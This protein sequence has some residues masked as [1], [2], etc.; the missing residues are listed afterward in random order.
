VPKYVASR[1]L[2]EPLAWNGSSV[3]AGDLAA[4]VAAVREQHDE[5]HVIGSLDLVQ[6]LLRLALVDRL[7]LWLFPVLLGSGKQVFADGTVPTALRLTESV[8]H[9]NGTL[10][11]TYETAGTPTY[12]N[13]AIEEQNLQ[14]LAGDD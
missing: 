7:N 10:Q 11:L 9:P 14:H 6:S 2:A 8:T 4:G 13:L 12:G 1:T 5:V 3:V